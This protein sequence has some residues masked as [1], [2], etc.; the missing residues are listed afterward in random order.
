MQP[1]SCNSR[2]PNENS[3]TSISHFFCRLSVSYL[4]SSLF[5]QYLNIWTFVH[6]HQCLPESNTRWFIGSLCLISILCN[7]TLISQ[8][9]H[10]AIKRPLWYQSNMTKS[11]ARKQCVIPLFSCAADLA[12]LRQLRWLGLKNHCL[13]IRNC[14][15]FHARQFPSCN[16]CVEF[17]KIIEKIFRAVVEPHM[18]QGPGIFLFFLMAC[19]DTRNRF[20]LFYHI[21]SYKFT[22]F[23]LILSALFNLLSFVIA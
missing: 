20:F 7:L 14:L 22:I 19:V 2:G 1:S 15:Q 8:D 9:G 18:D 6:V 21:F 23:A 4:F 10:R 16:I 3:S 12:V 17:K 5:R 11:R 13:N